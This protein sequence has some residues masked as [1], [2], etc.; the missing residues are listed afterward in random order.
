MSTK[1]ERTTAYISKKPV[2]ALFFNKLGYVGTSMV[3]LTRGLTGDLPKEPIY[4]NL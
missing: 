3:D 1:A 4:G 2:A